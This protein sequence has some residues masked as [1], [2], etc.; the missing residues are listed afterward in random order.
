MKSKILLHSC[1]APCSTSTLEKIVRDNPVS[2]IIVYYYNPNIYPEQEEIKR[3]EELKNYIERRYEEK[4]SLIKGDYDYSIWHSLVEPLSF[5]K[6]AGFRCRICYYL[7]LLNAFKTAKENRC[8]KVTTTLSIS[9]YKKFEWLDE[10]GKILSL[11]YDID[12]FL[13]KWDYKRSLSLSEEYG[14]YRQNYCG[15]SFSKEERDNRKQRVLK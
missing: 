10:I 2:D 4:I 9:P 15:C 12:W 3:F 7:R 5:S 14:L 1:C 13:E 8:T 11:K 6:E